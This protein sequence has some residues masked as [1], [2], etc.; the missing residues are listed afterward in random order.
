MNQIF[1]YTFE[2]DYVSFTF[3]LKI[4]DFNKLLNASLFST[5]SE[6]NTNATRMHDFTF[7]GNPTTLFEYQQHKSLTQNHN[8]YNA[9]KVN[10]QTMQ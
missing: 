5:L 6:Y 1:E 8:T 2:Y 9:K 4:N 3:R 7:T 10:K